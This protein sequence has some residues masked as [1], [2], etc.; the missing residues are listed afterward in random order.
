MNHS[1]LLN[2]TRG[3][4]L[5]LLRTDKTGSSVQVLLEAQHEAGFCSFY[6][7]CGYNPLLNNTL[8]DP[9]VPCYNFTPALRL[10]G[11]HYRKLRTV[12]QR[13]VCLL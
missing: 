2:R 3:I 5:L 13:R 10:A 8:I 7:E 1:C 12:S 6:E 4:L 9:I 11:A